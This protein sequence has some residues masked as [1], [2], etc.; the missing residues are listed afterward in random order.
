MTAPQARQPQVFP[1]PAVADLA[2]RVLA[3]EHRAA[4]RLITLIESGDPAAGP[5]LAELFPH[6]GRAMVVGVTGPPGAGKSTL[7]EKLARVPP[8]QR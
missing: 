7:T 8:S 4:A 1:R 6:T 2:S 3:G 5:L